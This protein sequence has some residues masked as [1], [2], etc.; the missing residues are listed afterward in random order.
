[1]AIKLEIESL[2]TV[3][4]RGCFVIVRT[5]DPQANFY[6]TDKSFL[7]G[8]ELAK[9]LDIP[10]AL[11]ENRNQRQDIVALQLK[12]QSDRDKLSKGAIVEI[13]PGDEIHFLKP[14]YK[15]ENN[16]TDLESELQKE[17]SNTHLLK[18]KKLNAI[19]R[20]Q[21]NDDVLFQIFDDKN[22]FAVVH[23][24][25]TAKKE[26][27]SDYPRTRLFQNWLDLYNNC[28]VLDHN[29]FNSEI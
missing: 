21:D 10:R 4:N 26:N 29:L 6:V 22:V 1:M 24:T 17:I 3:T 20:R 18:N 14:W 28:I 9:Y 19:A 16:D 15:L 27:D 5:I 13:I 11:D 25:W 2:F 8:V 23:L 7:G 12:N